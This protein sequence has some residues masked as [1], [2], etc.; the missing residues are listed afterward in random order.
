MGTRTQDLGL[1]PTS[2]GVQGGVAKRLRA[3][4][5]NVLADAPWWV[6]AGYGVVT[7]FVVVYVISVLARA[8]QSGNTAWDGW[9]V[10]G[11]ELLASCLCFARLVVSRQS[12]RG[13]G[14]VLALGAGLVS[15]AVGDLIVAAHFSSATPT[16]AELCYLGFYPL[17]YVAIVLL[18]RQQVTK[19]PAASW[20]DGALAGLG[21]AAVCAAFAFKDL[22]RSTGGSTFTTA[23]N[24]AYPIGDVL[25]L[26]LV[27]GGSAMLPGR[28]RSRWV[29]VAV[30]CSLNAVGDTFNL[31]HNTAG[32]SPVGQAF[33][34]TAWPTAIL[35]M[36]I[37]M[38]TRAAPPV[39]RDQMPTTGFILP[40]LSAAAGLTILT[41]GSLH[42]IGHVALGLAAATL[43]VAG[44]RLTLSVSALK[45][46][47]EQRHRQSITDDLTG[48]GNRRHLSQ[49]FESMTAAAEL[50]RGA[51]LLAPAVAREAVGV[52]SS[53]PPDA[54]AAASAPPEAD[55]TA[56]LLFVDLDRFKE[57][58]DSFG[59]SVGDELLRQIGPRLEGSLRRGD[60]LVRLG[61]DEFAVV[62]PSTDEQQAFRVAERLVAS[63]EQPFYL[64]LIPVQISAS[65]GIALAPR[66]GT[67]LNDILRCADAAMYSAKLANVPVQ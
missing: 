33:N 2:D 37:A 64:D 36:S 28:R 51:A 32:A 52:G 30:A 61:G 59:H 4:A 42:P 10:A 13:R 63:L 12:L 15:W 58:N 41:V 14:I 35:L 20:L 50:E 1:A 55:P 3:L 26:A 54:P 17:S 25:L 53:A 40:G 23:M 18:L 27:I 11:V 49:L 44:L 16:T 5:P 34:A 24:V 46:V 66:D 9:T 21:A 45:S 22:L 6:R 48:L 60:A 7:I 43:V 62:L 29:L 38:W 39:V 57:V 65:I 56:A 31:L 19:L 47:T 8:G 67:E